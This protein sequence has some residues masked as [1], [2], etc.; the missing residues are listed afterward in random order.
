[1]QIVN[2]L[3]FEFSLPAGQNFCAHTQRA[4][5]GESPGWQGHAHSGQVQWVAG[6]QW[7][8][9]DISMTDAR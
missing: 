5:P 8:L 2:T 6:Q 1:M 9:I 3:Y 4:V 7:D